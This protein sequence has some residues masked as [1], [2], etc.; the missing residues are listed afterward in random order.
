[1]HKNFSG[2]V[3]ILVSDRVQSEKCKNAYMLE[4]PVV[5][6]TWLEECSKKGEVIDYTKFILPI[7][8]GLEICVTQL[9]P[10]KQIAYY[11]LHFK[12]KEMI[13]RRKVFN[14]VPYIQKLWQIGA[15]T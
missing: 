12:R 14:T 3:Q 9:E 2:V 13:L 5:D 7:F 15:L 8:K 4:I 11:I 10:R 6:S 1:V